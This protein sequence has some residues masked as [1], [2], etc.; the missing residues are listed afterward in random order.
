M[1]RQSADEL[2][3]FLAFVGREPYIQ[4]AEIVGKVPARLHAWNRQDVLSFS[5]YPSERQ[6][7]DRA[8]FTRR[9]FT[10]GLHDARIVLGVCVL[11][12]R[13]QA[14]VV[15]GWQVRES[16]EISRQKATAKR[17]VRYEPH[18]QLPA[19]AQNAVLRLA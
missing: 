19:G 9:K 1:N 8:S 18:A 10:E 3:K 12:A 17:A 16:A 11:E 15:I 13:L 4:R 7:S 14:P 6:L 5:Q 2:G